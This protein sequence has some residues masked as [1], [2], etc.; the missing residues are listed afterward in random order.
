MPGLNKKSLQRF[1][2]KVLKNPMPNLNTAHASNPIY[3]FY[4]GFPGKLMSNKA[5][6]AYGIGR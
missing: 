6:R 3:Y 1:P 5:E 4:A 2:C